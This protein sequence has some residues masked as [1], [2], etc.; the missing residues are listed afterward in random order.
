M[1]NKLNF[2]TQVISNQYL[3]YEK[4]VNTFNE[5]IDIEVST[6]LHLNPY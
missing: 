1:L 5:V 3:H 4:Y 2:L 6:E